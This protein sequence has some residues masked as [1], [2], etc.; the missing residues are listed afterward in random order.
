MT[1][2]GLSMSCICIAKISNAK[3]ILFENGWQNNRVFYSIKL[4][5]QFIFSIANWMAFFVL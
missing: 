4:A 2:W 5:N 1:V 3:M